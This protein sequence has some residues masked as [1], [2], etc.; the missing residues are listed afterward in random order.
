MRKPPFLTIGLVVLFLAGVWLFTRKLQETS[1]AAQFE[2]TKSDLADSKVELE[3]FKRD[4][5]RFPST[6]E[7]LDALQN[8]PSKLKDRWRG[9]YGNHQKPKDPFGNP[10]LYESKSPETFTLFSYGADGIQGG[11]D[12]NEDLVVT[13]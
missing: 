11:A 2:I 5:G 13:N 9:P 12:D 4:C 8:P 10:Y 1:V 6:E 7:G 3:E